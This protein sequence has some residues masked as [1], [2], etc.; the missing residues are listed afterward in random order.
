[1]RDLVQDITSAAVIVGFIA[2]A[3]VLGA[4]MVG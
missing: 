4:A 1:M 2:T 3:L